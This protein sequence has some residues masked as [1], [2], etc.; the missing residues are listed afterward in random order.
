MIHIYKIRADV[1]RY[2]WLMPENEDGIL[3]L[4]TFDC[5]TKKEHW[6]TDMY[7]HNPKKEC[8]NFF[9][10]GGIGALA[11]DE[12]VLDKMLTIF[13]M[14]GEILPIRADGK[15]LYALNVMECTNALDQ[16]NSKWEYFADGTKGR[17]I[18]YSFHKNRFIESSLFKIP[19]TSKADVLTYSGLKDKDDEFYSLYLKYGFTG[20]IFEELFTF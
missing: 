5:V 13:E 4:L 15:N 6:K 17:I 11:F 10:L 14:A 2:Q 9:S 12:I 20:L 7:I 1:N 18:S 19:E 3:E 16:K 8:G